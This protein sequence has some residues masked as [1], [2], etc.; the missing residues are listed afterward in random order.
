MIGGEGKLVTIVGGVG[1]KS[2]YTRSVLACMAFMMM[3]HDLYLPQTYQAS[4]LSI[5]P[6]VFH[7]DPKMTYVE[8]LPYATKTPN[9]HT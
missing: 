2:L 1:L 8:Q 7:D 9:R 3:H 4:H 5:S 6:L